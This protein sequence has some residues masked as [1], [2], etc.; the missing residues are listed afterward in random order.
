MVIGE[1]YN[2]HMVILMFAA[3]QVY[4]AYDE[5][6]IFLGKDSVTALETLCEGKDTNIVD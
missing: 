4:A 6:I 3:R 2:N 1:A 5:S